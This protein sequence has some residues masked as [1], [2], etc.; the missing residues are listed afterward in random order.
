[1]A[2]LGVGAGVVLLGGCA[3]PL[4]SPAPMH[5]DVKRLIPAGTTSLIGVKLAELTGTELFETSVA[6]QVDRVLAE[7]TSRTGVNPRTDIDE[8]VVAMVAGEPVLVARGRFKAGALEAR[9]AAEGLR[10]VDGVWTREGANSSAGI[11]IRA[12]TA[13]AG[14]VDAV[15]SALSGGRMAATLEPLLSGVDA[16]AQVWAV[17][18]SDFAQLRAPERSNLQNLEKIAGSLRS[19]TAWADLRTGIRLRIA[20]NCAEE[21]DARRLHSAIRAL[22][23]MGRLAARDNQPDLLKVFDALDVRQEGRL[24]RASVHLTAD[25]FTRLRRGIFP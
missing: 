4:R 2:F 13:V 22:I 11:A 10:V 5:E 20:G 18:T 8:F 25:Q 21:D 23:G 7:F 9:L 3:S 14:P 24:V 19:V 16:V 1:M 12:G 17:S 6:P 15:R